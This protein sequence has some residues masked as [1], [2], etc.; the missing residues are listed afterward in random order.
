MTDLKKKCWRE[1]VTAEITVS[2]VVQFASEMGANLNATEVAQLLNQNG[3]AQNVWIHM[4]QA[5]EEFLK[6]NLQSHVPCVAT[7]DC[8]AVSAAMIQ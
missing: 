7:P 1:K 2:H 5:G 6:A 8:R 3:L 4:M